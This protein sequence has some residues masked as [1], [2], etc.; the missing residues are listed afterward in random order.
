MPADNYPLFS[1]RLQKEALYR[2]RTSNIPKGTLEWFEARRNTSTSPT[3]TPEVSPEVTAVIPSAPPG[4]I[5]RQKITE[6]DPYEDELLVIPSYELFFY[7]EE[8][9]FN[10]N[11]LLDYVSEF[12]YSTPLFTYGS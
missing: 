12:V 2:A 10:Y 6:N 5:K 3:P 8:S 7:Q 1:K 4:L 11:K 9:P